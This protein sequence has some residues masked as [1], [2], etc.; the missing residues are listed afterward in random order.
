L[1]PKRSR[2]SRPRA[3]LALLSL[4][5]ALAGLAGTFSFPDESVTAAYRQDYD[6][7]WRLL[8]GVEPGAE[9]EPGIAFWRAALTQL[10]LYDSGQPALA[11]SFYRLSDRAVAACKGRLR[12]DPQ[13]ARA[14]LYLGMTQLNRANCQS[15]Q[16]QRLKAV[17]TMLGVEKHLRRAVAIDSSL[18]DGWFG[19]GVIE[20]FK[21]TADRYVFGLGVL[22][23]SSR[24][25]ELVGR[26]ARSNGVLC[27]AARFLKAYMHKEDGEFEEAAGLCEG[28][29]EQY[30]GNRAA[31]RM[32]RDT[33]L[34]AGEHG[35][36][37][38]LGREIEESIEES[39][40]GNRYGIAENRLQMARAWQRSGEPDS[41]R[42][43]VEALVAWEPY[44]DSVPWLK[45]YIADARRLTR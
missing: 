27:N 13:D 2:S 28:L 19:I 1:K 43:L 10:L 29:L 8:E 6:S 4:V 7:A 11:D 32:L 24:A 31:L 38:E 40:P 21:A 33:Q 18:A 25:Y 9:G 20:Y 30:P 36:V 41:A 16:Q 39:F 34:A 26:A 37:I 44:Q 3:L 23:S 5:C 17:F 35:Q 45:N 15:W 22:G 14:H 42:V 12:D